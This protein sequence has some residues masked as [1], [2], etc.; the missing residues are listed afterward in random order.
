MPIA[1]TGTARSKAFVIRRS[2]DG[3]A[4]VGVRSPKPYLRRILFIEDKPVAADASHPM[5]FTRQGDA[6]QVEFDRDERLDIPDMLRVG[7]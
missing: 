3:A 2:F 1:A 4:T 5:S 7:G 6:T